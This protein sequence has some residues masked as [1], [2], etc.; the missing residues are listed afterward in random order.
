MIVEADRHM[1][2]S[3][4]HVPHLHFYSCARP[5]FF[6][7]IQS[8]SLLI[9]PTSS[10]MCSV[11]LS[12]FFFYRSQQN[13]HEIYNCLV[14]CWKTTESG[15]QSILG[16]TNWQ[17]AMCNQ[18]SAKQCKRQNR[19]NCS[20]KLAKSVQL[21]T[22]NFMRLPLMLKIIQLRHRSISISRMKHKFLS[23][24]NR[25]QILTFYPSSSKFHCSL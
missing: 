24:I 10:L 18:C 16:R 19:S 12:R 4:Y 9:I 14:S 23:F 5:Q 8:H 21:I 2:Y 17:L 20:R 25:L 6:K 7:V 15:S 13:Q 1:N 22:A 3:T 11:F